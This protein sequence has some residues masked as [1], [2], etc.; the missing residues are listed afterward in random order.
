MSRAEFTAKTKRYALNRCAGKCQSCGVP[1]TPATGVEFHHDLECTYGG[2]NDISN[3]VVL[4]GNCHS[5]IT[6]AR[7]SVIAKSNRVRAKHLGLRNR[8]SS[9]ATNKDGQYKR[10]FYSGTVRRA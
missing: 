9:F 5:N 1:L 3:C 10:T 2:N 8:R 7:V 4:C 6:I